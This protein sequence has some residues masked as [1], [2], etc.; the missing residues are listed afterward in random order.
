MILDAAD[1]KAQAM[2][3][4][5]AM[6]GDGPPPDHCH[7]CAEASA[8]ITAVGLRA[9]YREQL[10][11]THRFQVIRRAELQ[12]TLQRVQQEIDLLMTPPWP[13]LN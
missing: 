3:D 12:A 9:M 5:V 4:M 2:L 1:L 13:T 6:R 10:A 11:A 8:L 7:H